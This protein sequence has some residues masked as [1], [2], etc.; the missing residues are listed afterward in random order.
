MSETSIRFA[1]ALFVVFASVAA[2]FARHAGLAA[3]QN[4]AVPTIGSGAIG[5]CFQAEHHRAEFIHPDSVCWA[6]QNT[7]DGP[8]V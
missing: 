7:I 8:G 1:F 4:V 2:S 3:T 6:P 5:K